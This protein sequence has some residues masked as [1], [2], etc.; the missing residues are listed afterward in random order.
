VIGEHWGGGEWGWRGREK[1][2]VRAKKGRE[3]T[4]EN[5]KNVRHRPLKKKGCS[6]RREREKLT[7]FYE[8]PSAHDNKQAKEVEKKG[9]FKL[10]AK[11]TNRMRIYAE[12]YRTKAQSI[13]RDIGVKKGGK[14]RRKEGES[15]KKGEWAALALIEKQ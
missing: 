7:L 9:S 12:K 11:G 13:S 6:T 5:F 15:H 3:K 2:S 8:C 10:P 1:S 4:R 14:R